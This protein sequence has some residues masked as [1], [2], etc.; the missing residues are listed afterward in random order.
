MERTLATIRTT[1]T[2]F[3]QKVQTALAEFAQVGYRN[4]SC[5]Q[6][7][8]DTFYVSMDGVGG[9]LDLGLRRLS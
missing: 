5:G 8:P 9:H 4:I 1:P 7:N 2:E 6:V 3:S